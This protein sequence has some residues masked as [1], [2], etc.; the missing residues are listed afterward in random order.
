M[1]IFG[2]LST[3][4]T[5]LNAQ[6]AAFTDISDNIAN[7]QTVG[8]KRVD[9]AFE[10]L[11]SSSNATINDSGGVVARPVYV[12]TVQGT[13]TQTDNPLSMAIAGP[14][15][16]SVSLP[17]GTTPAGATLFAPLPQYT[18]AGGFQLDKEGHMVNPGG[19]VLNGWPVDATGLAN[20]AAL[21][22]ITI[23]KA[24]APPVE[25]SLVTLA[26]NLPPAGATTTP[27]STPVTVYDAQGKTH[28]LTMTFTPVAGTPNNWN[29]G[30]TDDAGTS[31]GSGTVAFAA[32]GTL[33]AVGSGGVTNGTPGAAGIV[34]LTTSY[35]DTAGSQKINLSLGAIGKTT[36]LT[37][38]AGNQYVLH[39]VDQNGAPPGAFSSVST[40][41]AGNVVVS[42]DNGVSK[43]VAQVPITTFASPDQL[44]RQ[45]GSAFSVT[46]A[47][48][49][50]LAQQ[51]GVNGAGAIDASSAEASNVDLGAEFS[52]LIV[53]QRA[54]AANAKLV[55]TAD[56]L[57][58]QTL[59]MK[60]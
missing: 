49:A 60:R 27:V 2:A 39:S 4:V 37:Q 54:Y 30:V 47:S 6:S 32:D 11:L 36:A 15:F 23:D 31:I 7:S 52:Q 25:T 26:A 38:F 34:K 45:S 57:L 21:G 41:A 48:G 35:P 12:N 46:V 9:T 16:F 13:I 19:Q 50:P 3:A 43:T 8:Y 17:A 33:A 40:T 51:A 28:Q 44:Q 5:G 59:D 1:S 14:G 24:A 18:R 55:T 20:T 42:Y 58:Q 29:L 22:P 56:E 53:A 10:S